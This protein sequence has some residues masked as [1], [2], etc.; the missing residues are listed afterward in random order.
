MFRVQPNADKVQMTKDTIMECMN[1][2]L[3][4]NNG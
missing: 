1:D 3:E 4:E 2:Y